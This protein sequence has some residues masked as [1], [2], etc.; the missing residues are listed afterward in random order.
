MVGE[1]EFGGSKGDSPCD[2]PVSMSF[3][4]FGQFIGPKLEFEFTEVLNGFT[5]GCSG[6]HSG[7]D[8][9]Q[10][11]RFPSQDIVPFHVGKFRHL[12]SAENPDFF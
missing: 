10:V 2:D 1:N 8:G 12:L 6:G 3:D 4:R 7:E 5:V 11:D 9:I